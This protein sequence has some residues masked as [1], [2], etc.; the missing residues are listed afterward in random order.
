VAS[1]KE[2]PQQNTKEARHSQKVHQDGNRHATLNIFNNLIHFFHS[3]PPDR[4]KCN[5]NAI[6]KL[7]GGIN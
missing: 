6:A 4:G 3:L 1:K 7:N 2:Q 5:R